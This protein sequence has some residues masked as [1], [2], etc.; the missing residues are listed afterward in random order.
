MVSGFESKIYEVFWREKSSTLQMI[1]PIKSVNMC[2]ISDKTLFKSAELFF[3][4]ATLHSQKIVKE[5][6]Y[7]LTSFQAPFKSAIFLKFL[8]V[9]NKS[10]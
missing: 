3:F 1:C 4:T 2:L 10:K 6:A 8:C 5:I 7:I 9:L